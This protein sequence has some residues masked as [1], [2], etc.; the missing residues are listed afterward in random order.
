MDYLVAQGCTSTTPTARRPPRPLPRQRRV[1]PRSATSRST[2]SRSVPHAPVPGPRQDGPGTTRAGGFT[3]ADFGKIATRRAGGPRRRRD[4]G[5]DAVVAPRRADRRSTARRRDAPATYITEGLRLAP[6]EPSFL[7]MR[8]AI[9]A[10]SPAGDD[11]RAD[12]GGVRRARD[13]LLR[14]DRRRATT[15]RRSP[16]FTDP[17]TAGS[18]RSPARS[19]T[20]TA[21]RSRRR[22]SASP[23]YDTRRSGPRT[24]RTTRADGAYA[25]TD[26]DGRQ[27]AIPLVR[28]R[29]AG[30][31]ERPRR[32]RRRAGRDAAPLRLPRSRATGPRPP[33]A[34]AVEASP[35]RT[36][37][38]AAAGPAG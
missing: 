18:G 36:T 30:F 34:R 16:D 4:L 11:D 19:A 28:A 33:A 37:R 7:D 12:L 27:H 32:G 14:R 10:A 15:S 25:I 22:R 2:A 23:G 13:G 6:A 8:N 38:R 9:L 35:A 24:R 1:R 5:A 26:P 3:Y 20:R 29:K 31:G 17:A 21:S